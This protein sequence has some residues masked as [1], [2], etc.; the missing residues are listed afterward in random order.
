MSMLETL[1]SVVRFQPVETDRV[2]R[3]L[4]RAASVADL[5]RIARQRLPGGVFDY[6]DGAAE[7]E[8][9]MAANQAAF[10]GVT[11]RPRVL[12]GL[13]EVETGSTLLGRPLAYPLVLAPTGFTRIADPAGE[14]AV[15]R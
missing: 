11:Y 8:R 5:R 2:E 13:G 4:R 1:R 9:T 12:R 3:R 10:A 6:I 15:A 14:L 7:D